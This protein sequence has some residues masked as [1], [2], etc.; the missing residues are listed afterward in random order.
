MFA[1]ARPAV[2]A[3]A[4]LAGIGAVALPF[5]V[6]A[7]AAKRPSPFALGV[8]RRR[9]RLRHRA[10]ARSPGSCDGDALFHLAR[11]RKLDAFDN[12]SLESVDE[13]V[14]G[15]L[16]PG[17]AFPLWHVLLALVARLAGVDPARV[18]LHE[19]SVL[20]PVAFLVAYEAGE[21]VFRSAWGG[22]RGAARAGRAH[23][24]R[25]GQ[26]RRVHGARA[27]GDGGAPAARAGRDRARSSPSSRKPGWAPGSTVAA[28]SLALAL[29]HPTYALFVAVPLAGYV[30]A[31]ALLARGELARGVAGL[32]AVLAPGRGG[33]RSGCAPIVRE[34]ASHNPSA[35]E[36]APRRSRTTRA[37]STS[38]RTDSYRLAPEVF[39]RSGAVAVAA[40]VAVPLAALA[41]RR[42]WAAFVLGGFVAVLAL[43]LVPELFTPLRRRRLALAGAAR[44]RLRPVRVRVRRRRGRARPAASWSGAAG[45]RSAAGIALQLAY[46]GD[47]GYALDEGGPAIATW[48]ALVGGAA[49]L[50]VAAVLGRRGTRDDRGPLSRPSPPPSSC[51]SRS[52]A[53]PTGTTATYEPSPL[54]PGLVERLEALPEGAVVFSDDSTSYRIAAVAPVYVVARPPGHVAD[55]KK[56]RPYERRDDANRFCRTGDLAIPRRYRA[57]YVLVDETAGRASIWLCRPCTE[58]PATFS[59]AYEGA[60]RLA[61][62]PAGRRRRRPA[63]AEVRDAPARARASRRT[64]SRRTTRSGCTATTSCSRRRR[65]GSTA[66]ATSAREGRRPA[67][68]L[69]GTTGPRPAAAP[70]APLRPPAARPRRERQLEPDRDP[71][72]DP[73]RPPRGDR[74][75]ADD[76]AARLRPLRRRRREAPDRRALGRRPARLARRPSAPPRRLGRAEGEGAQRTAVARLVARRADAIVAASDAIADETRSLRPARR[77]W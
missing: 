75:R 34:T 65:R 22:H 9:G 20:V 11:V 51:R 19:A 37:S 43:M 36:R 33:R 52:T 77:R 62:L 28:A 46:P 31:R 39:G 59:T 76:V 4:L 13:F 63:A 53:S 3:L 29:V 49:A 72:R 6:M 42:R 1:V 57:D 32:A 47:F 64:C 30:V 2:V 21:A 25:A 27:A 23:R 71:G 14:D 44:G 50:V 10:L 67:E 5:A 35:D 18:V 66:R 26:R 55:T 48:I 68:E 58:T 69:H 38:S 17:Y 8:A 41:S 73:H 60:A 61:L 16:H 12:L 70:G 56:N 40:L 74:R 45:R 7:A 15:G 24:A 54:T